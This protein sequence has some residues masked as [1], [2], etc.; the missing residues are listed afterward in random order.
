MS[1]PGSYDPKT[2]ESD[3]YAMWEQGKHFHAE[4]SPDRQPYSIVIPPPNVTGALHL[5][6]ALNNTLQDLLIRRARMQGFETCWLPGTDH[7]GIATQAKV[8]KRLKD[9]E[10][11]SRHELGRE[12]LVARIWTW[13]EEYNDRI[14]TQLRAMGCS[15]DWERTRFTLDEMCANAVYETFYRLFKEGLIFR[16]QRLVNWD[17]HLQTAVADD[18]IVHETV[19]GNLWHIRYP[20]LKDGQ[21]ASD[22]TKLLGK[23]SEAGRDFLIVATTRPETMLG[24]TAVAV[25][26]ADERY[27]H[28]IGQHVLLPLQNRPIPIIADPIL[29]KKEFG[30]GCVKVTPAHDPNDYD[31]GLRNKLQQINILTVDGKINDNGGA[32]AGLD[33]YDARKKVVADLEAAGLLEKTEPHT[34]EVGHSDRSKTPIEPLLS[35]Q[36]FL[37]MGAIA[38]PALDAVRDGR[39]TFYPSRYARTFQ[40]WLGEKRDWCISRQLWWGHRIPVWMFAGDPKDVDPSLVTAIQNAVAEG[41]LACRI[42]GQDAQSAAKNQAFPDRGSVGYQHYSYCPTP[43]YTDEFAKLA[44][45]V[46]LTQDEDVLDTWFSSA[47][48][49][50]STF[51]WPGDSAAS[52]PSL[53]PSVP[54]SLTDLSYF[55]P[56]SVLCT[57]RDI[58]SLWV[59]RMMVTGLYNIG[60]VPFAHVYIHPVIQDGQGRRMSKSFGNGLDPLDLID[61][62]GADAMRFTL[63]Q[64]AGETQDVRIPIS[65]HCPH[66]EHLTPH[67]SIVPNNKVPADIKTAKCKGCGKEFATAWASAEDKQRLGTAYDT[68]ERFE[69]GRNLCNKLWQASSGFVMTGAEKFTARPLKDSDL[70]LEDRWILSRLNAAIDEVDGYVDRYQFSDVAN[71]LYSFFWSDFCDWYIELV[72]PRLFS[73]GEDGELVDHTD[74]SAQVAKQVL[75]WVLDQTL[76]LMHPMMPFI[77][78][79]L[80]DRLGEAFPQRGLAEPQAFDTPL[81]RAAWPDADAI[82]RDA[83]AEQEVATLREVIRALREIRN[84]VNG[85]RAGAKETALKSLPRAVIKAPSEIAARLK[86]RMAVLTR[87]GQTD[88]VEI[89]ADIEKPPE[90]ASDV[91]DGIEVYVPLAGLADLDLERKRLRKERDETA[92]HLQRLEG[93]LKNEGFIAKAPPAVVEKERERLAS[94][95]DK[96]AAVTRNLEEIDG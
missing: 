13:K 50:H 6:H 48:W 89:G 94:L 79:A 81:I 31:C 2:V 23:N 43:G 54:A 78:E 21:E 3:I 24:D 53:R 76:R 36:W 10:G 49:P 42:Q 47:L 83:S 96:L 62:Y 90:C 85:I 91:F 84:R 64:I 29:V 66:C 15:C 22:A 16:G 33:R 86:Q 57:A 30:S 87:L 88:T 59:A 8:E 58:I 14:I 73:R 67:S 45:Q 51:G 92:G 93:K 35:E 52:S 27:A 65:Y 69:L 26:P 5:G 80:W 95:K 70:E 82:P 39:T 9:E 74:D 25:H 1:T 18:E 77:T 72:K 61:L 60:R 38:D 34:H 44:E 28:L 17:A 40:D 75:A 7:A 55:Y 71:C 63:T 19:K 32:Y 4:P 41:K 46:G 56:T 11:L 20:I 68:S 12:G 37:N